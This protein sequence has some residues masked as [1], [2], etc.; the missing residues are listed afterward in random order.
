VCPLGIQKGCS[1]SFS[2]AQPTFAKTFSVGTQ[3]EALAELA[4]LAQK[5]TAHPLVRNTA[6]KIVRGCASR[7][8]EC[9]LEA[10]FNAVKHGDPAVKPLRK[11]LKYVADPRW[12][13]Y[14][15]S[16]VD[17]LTMCLKDACGSDCDGHTALLVSL[18][19]S[20]GWRMGLRAWGPKDG[21]ELI[22]VYAVAAFP[23]RP[24]FQRSIGLDTTVPEFKL[25]SEPP[26][27]NVLT[28]WLE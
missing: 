2:R 23:K 13:D 15:E 14:F 10:I 7:D 22:H 12:T 9:E 8:D 4:E 21:D 26:K 28:A 3:K 27:G 1:V 16:P 11:G 19:G 17:L 18:A 5:A 6:L 25:G 20:L 24:P